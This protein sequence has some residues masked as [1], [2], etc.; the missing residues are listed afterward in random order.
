[1]TMLIFCHGKGNKHNKAAINS[2]VNNTGFLK[3]VGRSGWKWMVRGKNSVGNRE[4]GCC[5]V[6][7]GVCM[8]PVN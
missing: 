1:M 6:C 2:I 7:V 8:C 5:E 3:G 4:D